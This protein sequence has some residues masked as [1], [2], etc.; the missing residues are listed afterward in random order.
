MSSTST[1]RATGA[2]SVSRSR[3]KPSGSVTNRSLKCWLVERICSSV[4]R[5]SGS[6]SKNVPI[7]SGLRAART[8]RSRLF[9]AMSGSAQ[10]GK[11]L[12]KLLADHRQ[13]IERNARHGHRQN[14]P[15]PALHVHQAQAPQAKA[16]PPPDRRDICEAL[17]RPFM[18]N[19]NR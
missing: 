13:Q 10:P 3:S 8:N 14:I 5:A 1:C 2:P 11:Y 17:E 9:S 19:C 18:Y 15:M 7:D 12:P 16:R 4:G 6:R